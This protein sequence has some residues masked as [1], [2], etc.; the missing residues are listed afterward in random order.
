MHLPRSFFARPTLEVARELLGKRLVRV[1]PDGT[2]LS[3]LIAE[4]EA[5]TGMDD[6]G[7]HGR[8]GRTKRNAA[9]WGEAGHAYVY[10]NYGMHWLLNLVTEEAGH[11]AAVLVRGMCATHGAETIRERRNG[12]P[13]REWTDGPAKL[14]QALDVDGALDG[15]DLCA[16]ESVLYLEEGIEVV[17]AVTVAGPRIGLNS[18]PEPWKSIPWN[19][20]VPP[21]IHDKVFS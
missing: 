14:C 18:V 20:K 11:P 19:F 2:L 15:H 6:L 4:T 5:Y 21:E 16:P 1:E 9:M 12:R 17:E 3:G 7:C 13:E 8:S 10:F